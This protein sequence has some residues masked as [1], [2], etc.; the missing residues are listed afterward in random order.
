MQNEIDS[1]AL[2]RRYGFATTEPVLA[3]NESDASGHARRIGRPVAMKIVSAEIVHK[4]AAGGVALNVSVSEAGATFAR[5]MQAVRVKHPTAAI[6][7]VLIEEMVPAGIEIFIGGRH[8]PQFGDVVLL[9][10]GGSNVER[11]PRP[12]VALAPIDEARANKLIRE[13]I[14][15]EGVTLDPHARATLVRYL[16]AVAGPDSLLK[17][18]RIDEL[19]INPVIVSGKSA[20]AVD[21]VVKV[22]SEPASV[23][24]PS[25]DETIAARR[26]RLGDLGALFEPEAIALVGASTQSAKLGYRIIR[27]LIDFGFRGQ[28]Y[29]IHPSASDICGVKAY[30]DIESVPGKVDR[31]F[32][33]VGSHQ[34]PEVLSACARKGVKVAQVL[35]AGFSEWT[36][37]GEASSAAALEGAMK[38][39]LASTDMRMVGPNCIGTFSASARIA[40]GA[41]RFCPTAPGSITFISQSGTFAGDVVRR[42]QVQGIPV[43]R[44]LSCGNCIDLDL[45]DFLLFC[46][47]DPNTKLIAFY[48]ESIGNPGLFFRIAER[49]TKPIV[50]L[51]GGTTEQGHTAASSHT[52]ALATDAALWNAAV[53]QSGVLQ[54]DGIEDLMDALLIF[55]AHGE[56]RGNRLGIFGSG[57]GV[58]VTSS[59][60]AAKVGMT[61]PRLSAATAEALKR[62]GVPGTSVA[63]PIDI[64]VWGLKDGD[65]YILEEIA[66]HLKRDPSVDSVICY[67][68]VGSIMDFAD[69]EAE[70]RSQL[71]DICASIRR[72]RP[73]G[74]KITLVLRS[75]GDQMQDDFLREQRVQLLQDGI[76][77]FRSTAQAVR[78]HSKLLCMTRSA[79]AGKAA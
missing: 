15:Q 5:L 10:F 44:V 73:D 14:E 51:K 64:P 63:N 71:L 40:M 23:R 74:P 56:L 35:T 31:A 62:F 37:G 76:A 38:E 22:R 11:G 1:K 54:V 72:A 6:D 77:V 43:G 16:L 65:R 17:K 4:V 55:S 69:S 50:I 49:S 12:R 27:N 78:A 68:E 13:A 26:A 42:A 24:A 3:S 46:L 28:L 7:G 70:G 20:I 29:P 18:E 79:G 58:S 32:V 36:G 21:A 34:V 25:L 33:A 67:I 75:S 53:A 59:D 48:A 52:A 47:D 19:D 30:P 41:P 45:I 9:G 39:V 60:A 66:D 8:D 2:L 57:G 61:I